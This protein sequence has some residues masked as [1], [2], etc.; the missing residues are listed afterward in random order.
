MEAREIEAAKLLGS[1]LLF[2][3][4]FF[5]LRTGREF[6][7]SF[8][9][10]R[11]SHYLTICREL[12]E[13]FR[14]NTH[15]LIIN[16]PPGHGKSTLLSSFV[17][18]SLARYPDS[19][20]LYISYSQELAAK[21]TYIIKQ[22]MQHPYYQELFGVS[23][24]RDSSA[25]DNFSTTQG[26]SVKAFGSSGSIT[27]QDAGLPNLERF[28]GMVVMDD[29]HKP[30]EVF[31]DTTREHVKENYMHTIKI[32][33][34]GP[35]VPMVFIGQRLHED[36]LPGNLING[37]D[38]DSWKLVELAALDNNNNVLAPN[39]ITLPQLEKEKQFNPYV[40]SSQYQQRPIPAGGGVYKDE[41]WVLLDEE[42]EII[43]T[44]IVIDTAETDK[45]YN[46]ATAMSFFGLYRIKVNN[47]ETEMYGLHWI[48]CIEERVQPN[49]LE[50]LFMDFWIDCMRHT[51]KP[52]TVYIENKS[53]GTTLSSVLSKV[54]GLSIVP[55]GVSNKTGSKSSRFMASQT[56]VAKKLISLPK[57]GKHT[58]KVL[59]HMSK[60]T[61]NDSHRWD[62]IAD[63]FAYAIRL[64]YIDK[65]VMAMIDDSGK[66]AVINNIIE[67]SQII[68]RARTQQWQVDPMRRSLRN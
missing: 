6:E 30:D 25:K 34:R 12:T 62:D 22:I 31:S 45:T 8:P 53:T 16:V 13:V 17:A 51:V 32:R 26:G 48:D 52:S 1:L 24:K 23:I 29:M 9:H 57:F 7:L 36:D 40:F 28:S 20:F 19:N 64:V 59:K 63:T 27:G 39:L 65:V 43:S 21:H 42:P 18:W 2:T 41:W 56:Y 5:E 44:F 33:P 38:G 10:K 61:F 68:N 11:E 55:M 66:D 50:A 49:E 46:D 3:R 67:Q 35:N 15:R 14:L 60:I 54:R 37:F 4:T 47:T 58:D